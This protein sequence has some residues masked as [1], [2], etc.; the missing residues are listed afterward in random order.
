MARLARLA[1]C[2]A[3]ACLLSSAAIAETSVEEAQRLF[4][5]DCRICHDNGSPNGEYTPMSLIQAQ[6]E[7]FFDRKYERTHRKVMDEA[8]GGVP[9][10]EA[11]SPENLEKIKNFAID[12]AADTD[13]PMTCG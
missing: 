8:R 3:G 9:V 1:C 2:V 12:H 5:E 7:R 6:W 4:R 13:Q 11:I 10:T